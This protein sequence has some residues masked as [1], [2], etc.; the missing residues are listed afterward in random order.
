MSRAC[1]AVSPTGRGCFWHQK[2]NS[3][4]LSY[5]SIVVDG[6]NASTSHVSVAWSGAATAWRRRRRDEL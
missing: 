2:V 1:A 5:K 4:A 3:K 6:A